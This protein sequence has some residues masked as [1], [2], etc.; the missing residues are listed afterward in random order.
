VA[1]LGGLYVLSLHTQGLGGPDYLPALRAVLARLARSNSWVARGGEIASWWS[2]RSRLRLSLA[3]AGPS[4]LRV[5]IAS[6]ASQ[7]IENATLSL[8]PGVPGTPQA[9]LSPRGLA[10]GTVVDSESGRVRVTLPRLEPGQRTTIEITF[11][12]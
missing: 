3:S 10:L 2:S 5:D 9:R 7:P 1:R 12:R 11:V 8:Y 4:L 6:E